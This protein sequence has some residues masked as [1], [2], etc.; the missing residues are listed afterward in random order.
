MASNFKVF[1]DGTSALVQVLVYPRYSTLIVH[2]LPFQ[3]HRYFNLPDK[4][5]LSY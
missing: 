1:R 4:V 5:L 3:S 2:T